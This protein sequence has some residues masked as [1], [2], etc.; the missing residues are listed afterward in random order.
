M[1]DVQFSMFKH[2]YGMSSGRHNLTLTDK[3]G[4]AHTFRAMENKGLR[5]TV[6]LPIAVKD[7]LQQWPG[8]YLPRP[9]IHPPYLLM[10]NPIQPSKSIKKPKKTDSLCYT[11]N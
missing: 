7:R 6:L 8:E 11:F 10:E 4:L 2:A 1:V 5:H 3:G 9:S